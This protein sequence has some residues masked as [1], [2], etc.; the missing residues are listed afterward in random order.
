MSVHMRAHGLA[1][2][3]L[4]DTDLID[5]AEQANFTDG[6]EPSFIRLKLRDGV[7]RGQGRVNVLAFQHLILRHGQGTG[8]TGRL[9]SE[10]GEPVCQLPVAF[11]PDALG[12]ITAYIPDSEFNRKVLARTLHFQPPYQIVSKDVLKEIT[13]VADERL[14]KHKYAMAKAADQATKAIEADRALTIEGLKDKLGVGFRE[15]REYK[16][17]LGA[18]IDVETRRAYV[19]II[20]GDIDNVV[21]PKAG[22]AGG[23]E[24]KDKQDPNPNAAGPDKEPTFDEI[25]EMSYDDL[26][27]IAKEHSLCALNIGTEK[28][29]IAVL[30]HYGFTQM[31]EDA[32]E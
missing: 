5:L 4:S 25:A 23:S 9:S 18:L 29:R 14:A 17:D 2:G 12:R 32:A 24:N 20:D 6:W 11:Q 26:K 13:P 1:V 21:I 16:N 7:L 10:N 28:V 8:T 31:D 30:E 22:S 15:S 19:E 3:K 27:V